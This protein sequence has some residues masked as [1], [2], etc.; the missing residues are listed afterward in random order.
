MYHHDTWNLA[1]S[2]GRAHCRSAGIRRLGE[3]DEVGAF[4]LSE[5]ALFIPGLSEEQGKGRS[6]AAGTIKKN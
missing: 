2:I 1:G 3:P 5:K 6:D 4:L